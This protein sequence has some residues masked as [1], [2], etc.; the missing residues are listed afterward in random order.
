LVALGLLAAAC[1]PAAAPTPGPQPTEV[2][3]T[4][5]ELGQGA[6]PLPTI[7]PTVDPDQAVTSPPDLATP[8][9]NATPALPPWAPQPGDDALDRGGIVLD[10]NEILLLESYPVQVQLHL[11]GSRPTPCNEL[12]V[13]V[14]APDKHNQ[15]VIEVYTVSDPGQACTQNLAPFT[16]NINLGSYPSG[17][18]T[19]VVNGTQ[20]AQFTV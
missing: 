5:T 7:E 4:P 9:P 2:P 12:R 20:I 1:T 18:Y 6:T 13:A 16:E 11:E 17:D 15:I 8:D 3:T 14:A 19:V 10:V